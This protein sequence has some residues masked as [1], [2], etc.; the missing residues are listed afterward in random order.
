MCLLNLKEGIQLDSNLD[1]ELYAEEL[2]EQSHY[3]AAAA[4]VASA[5]TAASFFCVGGSCA[6]SFG[7]ASSYSTAG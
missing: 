7:T 4:T 2:P 5:L 6:S 1:L 3:S